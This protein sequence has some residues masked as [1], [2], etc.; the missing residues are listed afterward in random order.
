MCKM[1]ND[2]PEHVDRTQ[3]PE[4][5]LNKFELLAPVHYSLH[6]PETA[7]FVFVVNTA[8]QNALWQV[9]SNP[10]TR[11]LGDICIVVYDVDVHVAAF[12]GETT[13]QLITLA[14]LDFFAPADQVREELASF[15]PLDQVDDTN[16]YELA[17]MFASAV[18][19]QK[20]SKVIHV[21]STVPFED[22]EPFAS[23]SYLATAHG[24]NGLMSA[25]STFLF[26]VPGAG[27]VRSGLENCKLD[28]SATLC[29]HIIKSV[30]T[31]VTFDMIAPAEANQTL[32]LNTG[33]IFTE[34][35]QDSLIDQIRDA[36]DRVAAVQTVI[37]VRCSRGMSVADYQG[38]FA[39]TKSRDLI[40]FASLARD[41]QVRCNIRGNATDPQF[42]F[43]QVSILYTDLEKTRRIRVLTYPVHTDEPLD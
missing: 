11:L 41:Q 24:I 12:G 6:A 1:V 4:T 28:D 30:D 19:H 15:E 38:T 34:F 14:E 7:N 27:S 5:E 36:I 16:G 21:S 37:R 23:A 32:V 33:G 8:S 31:S 25:A 13:W 18:A 17:L 9:L 26:F 35:D 42:N 3:M 10:E 29:E 2:V 40:A 39:K 22:P 20:C 43:V